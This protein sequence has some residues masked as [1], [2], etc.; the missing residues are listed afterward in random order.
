VE[1]TGSFDPND[2]Q[3]FPQGYGPEHNIRPGQELEYRVRFQNTGTDT[4]FTV[5]IRDTLSPWLDPATVRPGAASHPYTWE[6]TGSGIL[7]VR[8]PAIALPDSNV[9]EPASHG[10]VSFRIA[11]QP[12]LETGLQIL[13]TASIYFDFNAPVLTNQTLHTI[14]LPPTVS[15]ESPLK[16]VALV[17]VSPNPV[18]NT[19]TISLRQSAFRQDRFVLADAR[20]QTL[21]EEILNGSSHVFSRGD[22]PA[23]VYFFYVHDGAGRWVQGGKL[24]LR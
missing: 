23:G 15:T 20:G 19:A 2:K 18:A 21:R 11:Q 16:P 12:G 3:G 5:V 7:I 17:L 8:F 4:A 13:N 24:V 10:F 1:N 14:A 9:N 22:L 6:L